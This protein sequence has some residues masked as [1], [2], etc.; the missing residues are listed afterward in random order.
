MTGFDAEVDDGTSISIIRLGPRND[1]E[2]I[3]YF[4]PGKGQTLI[5]DN[6]ILDATDKADQRHRKVEQAPLRMNM[7]GPLN[8]RGRLNAGRPHN[9][10]SGKKD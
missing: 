1:G 5:G 6:N 7:N 8:L 9:V 10:S 3:P 4:Q 2:T